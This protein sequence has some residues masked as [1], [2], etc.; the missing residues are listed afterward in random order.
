[1]TYGVIESEK[2]DL[3][4][5][6]A[7]TC[8]SAGHRCLVFKDI[9]H[10]T[11]VLHAT[12]LD[13][14]V[15]EHGRPGLNALDWLETMAP[16]WPELPSRTL[17]LAQSEL[18]PRDAARIQDLGV[19]VVSSPFSTIDVELVVIDELVRLDGRRRGESAGDAAQCFVRSDAG[20]LPGVQRRVC[21]VLEEQDGSDRDGPGLAR[22][23][24]QS[25]TRRH[26]RP[27]SR[28]R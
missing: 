26:R 6:I 2:T 9:A 10:M 13:T 16:S 25:G 4:R 3:V 20:A 18:T 5:M 12:P 1:M 15:L 17:L 23:L 11:R 7:L 24:G 21:K 19:E 28:R 8:E 14:L 27:R 22:R